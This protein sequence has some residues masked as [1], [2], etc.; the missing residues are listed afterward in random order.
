MVFLSRDYQVGVPK[1]PRLGLLQLWGAIT[2]CAIF[3]WRWGLMQSCSPHLE[4]S[5]GMSH[6]TYTQ[7]N[8][9]DSWLL[10]VGSQTANLTLDFSFGH[11]LCFRCLDG[12]CEPILNFYAPRDFQWYKE[13]LKPLKFDPCNCPLKIGKSTGTPTPQSETPW[14]CEG[15][16]PHTLSHSHE[17]VCDSR[18]SSWPATLQTLALVVSPRLGLRHMQWLETVMEIWLWVS[19]F[20]MPP[21]TLQ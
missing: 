9:V 16:F 1:L 17:Y 5:N 8:R 19:P 10:M 6:A 21:F 2:L 14:G 4:L 12:W 13:C 11:N 15:S 7:G 20:S 3:R 18:F